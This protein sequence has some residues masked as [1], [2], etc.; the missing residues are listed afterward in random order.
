M[1]AFF[2][3]GTSKGIASHRCVSDAFRRVFQNN[4]G[5]ELPIDEP[6]PVS[7]SHDRVSSVNILFVGP[8]TE[9]MYFSVTFPFLF[10][11]TGG[12]L[13]DNVPVS[14]PCSHGRDVHLSRVFL[15]SAVFAVG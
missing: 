3:K 6:S 11:R 10:K 9:G 15:W 4:R 14:L 12:V 5:V 7:F 2:D 1:M 13:N 8:N